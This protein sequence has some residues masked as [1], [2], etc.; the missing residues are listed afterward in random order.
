MQI[1]QVYLYEKLLIYFSFYI[2]IIRD[3]ESNTRHL[4][5]YIFKRNNILF[6]NILLLN[7]YIK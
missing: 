5:I 3:V 6:N 4:R 2:L 7:N 1:L